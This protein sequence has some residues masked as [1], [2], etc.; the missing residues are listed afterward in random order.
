MGLR[1]YQKKRDF[2][3]T[4]EPSG[5]SGAKKA[6]PAGA[7]FV[8]QKH[9]ASHLHYDFRLEMG[10]VLKSWAVPK[11]LPFT[12][13]ERRLAMRVEDHPIEYAD[14]EGTIAEG[15]YGAGTVM[16]WDRGQYEVQGGDPLGSLERGKLHLLL[17]GD[18]LNGEWALV[19]M[20]HPRDEGRETW[21]IFKAV[22]DAKPLSP[23][24]EDR[25][26]LTRRSLKQI[27]IDND[28]QWQSNRAASPGRH[29]IALK[30]TARLGSDGGNERAPRSIASP[31]E[32]MARN[33]TGPHRQTPVPTRPPNSRVFLPAGLPRAKPRFIQPMKALLVRNTPKGPDW[34]YE[35]K[36]DGYR[37]LALKDGQTIS[38]RSRNAKDLTD[39]YA[40]V[41]EALRS[42]PANQ[43]V[44]DG[45]IVA[46]DA[47]GRSS[48]QLLQS[49]LDP[50]TEKPPLLYYIFDILNLQGR[51]V[52]ELPL[53]QRKA[54]LQAL[55]AEMPDTV[56]FAASLEDQ[57]GRLFAEMKKH[58]LEG[59][60]AKQK[61]ST[62]EPGRRSGAW[63]K[64]KWTHEQEFVIGGCTPPKGARDF[65]G[66]ILV[67]FYEEEKL[68]FASKV[69]TGFDT[70]LLE[71]LYQTFQK[72]KQPTCAFANLPET[73]PGG[74][75]PSEMKKCTWLKPELVCQI[76]F[77][78]WTRD[79][80]L[81]H[82]VF[83]GLREDK[84]AF[85][86]VRESPD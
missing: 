6:A 52:T 20:R 51:D 46:V 34:V 85:E 74:L 57:S 36:F 54:L 68:L 9:A 77:T 37:A 83:L 23:R 2:R 32:S 50:K 71:S 8:V 53:I 38:L 84:Q 73:V 40:D 33:R 43:A 60:I 70:R 66:A 48:F 16:I 86:V 28:A 11:G 55:L 12:R 35:V 14:F 49:Y 7:R 61:R 1:E 22:E 82:P 24:A 26:V 81:R 79:R 13:G 44:L 4:S 64:F 62:Y 10:G 42:L 58:G 31:G 19:R 75:S 25:S 69:G 63:A 56:R 76:R 59:V 17:H 3:R 47:Q 5:Q 67:G 80:H 15:N 21:L 72:L 29:P 78:E 27:A 45:E 39:R 41:A 18:K 65:F 30:S